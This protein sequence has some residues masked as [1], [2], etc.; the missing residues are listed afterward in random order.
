MMGTVSVFETS[1]NFY[2]TA[3]CNVPQ[4]SQFYTHRR[5]NLKSHKVVSFEML[6]RV[7]WWKLNN[8]SEVSAAS[9][10]VIMEAGRIYKNVNQFY[11]TTRRSIPVGS[12]FHTRRH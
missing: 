12:H 4:D 10:V 11:E 2:Q 5:K 8:V 3:W 1:V 7:L 6:R 9:I